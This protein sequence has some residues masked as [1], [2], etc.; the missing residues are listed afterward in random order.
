MED[1]NLEAINAIYDGDVQAY[2]QFFVSL[3][4]L[5]LAV[6]A[7]LLEKSPMLCLIVTIIS[8][9]HIVWIWMRVVS[10]RCLYV[11][12]YKF[13]LCDY[14]E[15]D[16]ALIDKSAD[17]PE[18]PLS[19]TDYVCDKL[20]REKVNSQMAQCSRRSGIYYASAEKV[21]SKDPPKFKNRRITRI[22]LDIVTPTLLLIVW[23]T[24]AVFSLHQIFLV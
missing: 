7:I 1:K 5:L 6:G 19:D 24:F 16:G 18:H 10:T 17:A 9:V 13:K 11:D 3:H 20:L 15:R 2:R 14:F 21:R 8:T 22:K 12:F 4:S 23:F